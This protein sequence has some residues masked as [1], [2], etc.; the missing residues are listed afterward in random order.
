MTFEQAMRERIFQPLGMERATYF[1]TE[2]VLHSVAVGHL[3]A[4]PDS[5][6][7]AVPFQIPRRANPAGGIIATVSEMIRF[8]EMHIGDG[9]YGDVQILKPET[10]REMRELHTEADF[11]RRWGLGWSLREIDGVRAVEHTG[12]TNGFMGRLCVIPER[13]FALAIVTNGE[14]GGSVH[15]AIYSHIL[16]QVVG[17]RRNPPTPVALTREQLARFEGH[18]FTGLAD[19]LIELDSSGL[20][21]HRMNIDPFTREITERPPAHLSPI[22]ETIFAIEEGPLSGGFGEIILNPDGSVRF[23][24]AGGRLGIPVPNE[25]WPVE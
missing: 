23:L 18:Y 24:R 19:I 16:Q 13:K 21:M 6:R 11:T 12:A 15:S 17:F 14:N 2:A 1:A 8:A 5:I 10:A 20:V 7:I 25:E 3:D 22:S 4:G 9:S